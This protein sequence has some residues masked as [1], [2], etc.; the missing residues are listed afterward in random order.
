MT[1]TESIFNF[2]LVNYLA[3]M[4]I[5]AI[6]S[7]AY[8][9]KSR[10]PVA[11]FAFFYW[12]SIIFGGL[13]QG[14]AFND[15]VKAGIAMFFSVP[16]AAFM[17]KILEIAFGTP[18]PWKKYWSFVFVFGLFG[19]LT[20][21][22]DMKFA[23]YASFFTASVAVPVVLFLA[24][25]SKRLK[26]GQVGANLFWFA[27]LV[28]ILHLFNYPSLRLR[29]DFQLIVFMIS[30]WNGF[31]TAVSLPLI[32]IDA[33]KD[34]YASS[35]EKKIEIAS[36]DLIQSNRELRQ[37]ESEKT[38]LLRVLCHDIA[39]LGTVTSYSI[40]KIF[41]SLEL[42]PSSTKNS[43]SIGE[44]HKTTIKIMAVLDSQNDLIRNIRSLMGATS[45]KTP[46]VL[47]NV[48]LLR[49]INEALALNEM[50]TIE[51]GIKVRFYHHQTETLVRSHRATLVH[52]V[53]SNIVSN[54]IKFSR[55][56]G[57]IEI[58]VEAYAEESKSHGAHRVSLLIQDF[59]VGISAEKIP[60]L[61]SNSIA[62]TSLG[63]FGE[64]GTGFG[65]PIAD[66]FCKT[67]GAD[68]LV[69][70]TAMTDD[71]ENLLTG[72]KVRIVFDGPAT[73]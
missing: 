40:R 66:F 28:C 9:Y 19:F 60:L 13:T 4:V 30:F 6:I 3:L 64:S 48:D 56:D 35:L 16:S 51:K 17:L 12:L 59:G 69:E 1:D 33:I 32:I 52:C 18:V 72:T 10:L 15:P 20:I 34:S 22:L 50:R 23:V 39:N 53:L 27:C 47:E 54:A 36:Y 61:F 29:A 14:W 55:R 65:L 44:I 41:N 43:T 5:S 38:N 21:F 7:G 42:L 70:S 37:S 67:Y 24:L 68:L 63:T 57:E 25:I 71:N 26:Q 8:F 2:V 62:T 31:F 49:C 46:V 45:G 11:K 73:V 58:K